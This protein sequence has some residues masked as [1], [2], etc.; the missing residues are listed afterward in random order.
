MEYEITGADLPLFRWGVYA[1]TDLA[2]GGDTLVDTY[3][4]TNPAFLTVGEHTKLLTIGPGAI[5]LALPGAG[6]A[7]INGDYSLLV[8]SDDNNQIIEDDMDP[9][10]E[11][12]T[13]IFEGV[14]HLTGGSVYA[15]ASN[16]DDTAYD[17]NQT[18]LNL[19]RG[20]WMSTARDY[21]T[22]VANLRSGVGG[23]RLQAS[24]V[25]ATVSNDTH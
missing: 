16:G 21:P 15:H 4:E 9:F 22:R 23:Y 2:F 14:Y 8:V 20:E 24:G 18:A 12:N 5:Q 6:A 7:E 1:S 10:S 13:V 17:A 25:G 19:L 3:L 11:D